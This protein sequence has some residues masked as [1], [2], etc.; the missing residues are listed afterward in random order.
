MSERKRERERDR[1]R[2]RERKRDRTGEREREGETERRAS[3]RKSKQKTKRQREPRSKRIAQLP[4]LPLGALSKAHHMPRWHL[5]ARSTE[6]VRSESFDPFS[7]KS[8]LS[9]NT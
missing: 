6:S 8:L 3:E 1:E 9:T 7:A 2:E 5:P 4:T